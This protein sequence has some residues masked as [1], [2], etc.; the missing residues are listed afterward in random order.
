[1][2]TATPILDK[3]YKASDGYPIKIRIIVGN[4]QK[5]LSLGYRVGSHQWKDDHVIK[6][7]DAEII[8]GVIWSKLD[9]IK[10][11]F[12]DCQISG[13]KIKLDLAVEGKASYSFCDYLEHRAKQYAAKDQIV[14]DRKLRR[15]AKELKACAGADVP[16]DDIT[17]DFLRNYEAFLIKAENV[18]NTR[19]KKFKFLRQYFQEAIDDGRVIGTNPFKRYQIGT[20]PVK[21]EKLIMAEIKRLE[22]LS[23]QPGPVNDARNMFLFSYYCKGMR[24]EKCLTLRRSQI[25][26][27][28]IQFVTNKSDRHISV[29]IH[30]K[31]NSILKQYKSKDIVFPFLK[32]IPTN[33]KAYLQAV[34]S[35]NVIINRHLKLIAALAGIKINLTFHIARHSLAFHMKEKVNSIHVIKDVLGHADTKTTEIYLKALGDEQLDKEMRKIYGK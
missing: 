23:L 4:E 2:A 28:R 35:Y 5:N 6:H 8:N 30:E 18:E 31:L 19:H 33:A 24:F 14:M 11:Y 1:M 13:R 26:K 3:R 7:P 9:A 17:Q 12:A 16:F 10:R 22:T 29:R 15:F 32:E 25:N 20:T 21:K 27:G 34:D